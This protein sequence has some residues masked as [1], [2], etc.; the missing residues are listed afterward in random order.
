MSTRGPGPE[1]EHTVG[2]VVEVWIFPVKSMSGASLGSASVVDGGLE[3]DR[4]WAVVDDGGATVTAAKEPRLREVDARLLDGRL[5]LDVPGAQPGLGA[6][7]AAPALS[8]WLGRPLRLAHGDGAG[9]VD[10]AP[11]HVVS[12]TSLADA[13]HAESCDTCDVT[14]PRANLVLDLAGA[15]SE[16]DWIGATVTLGGVTLTVVRHPKHC[17]GAYAEVVRPGVVSVGDPVSLR[18]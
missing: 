3:G 15:T 8:E 4:A 17:L 9:F 7:E 18:R 2:S 14:A 5:V 6:E 16:R 13:A 1:S 11:V 10:V 12:R